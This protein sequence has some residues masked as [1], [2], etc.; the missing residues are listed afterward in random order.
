MGSLGSIRRGFRISFG[1]LNINIGDLGALGSIWRGFRVSFGVFKTNTGALGSI[2]G[3][4]VDGGGAKMDAGAFR[5]DLGDLWGISR[6]LPVPS[7]WDM[8]GFGTH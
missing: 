3:C 6:V 5:V 8:G 7:G 2:W 4:G 1:V